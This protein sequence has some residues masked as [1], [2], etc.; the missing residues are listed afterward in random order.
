MTK[1]DAKIISQ[2]LADVARL[3]ESGDQS[4]LS[5]VSRV[6][7]DSVLHASNAAPHKKKEKK[8]A[9]DLSPLDSDSVR[10][11]LS[12]FDSREELGEF[13]R[14]NYPKKTDIVSISRLIR[15][16]VIREDNYEALV[17]KLIDAT[18]GYKLRSRAIRGE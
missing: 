11:K 6:L 2:I 4:A 8:L 7:R 15:V 10:R 16:P 5:T 13:I 17:E 18:I 12:S 14:N 1:L 9:L 3:I